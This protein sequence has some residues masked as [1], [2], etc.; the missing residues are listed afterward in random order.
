MFCILRFRKFPRKLASEFGPLPIDDFTDALFTWWRT[1]GKS[2]PAWALAA[3]VA[4]AIS[5]NSAACERVFALLKTMFGEQQTSALSDM[6]Q[7][8]LML[9]TNKRRLG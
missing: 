5:P 3:R 6:I 8:A 7:A 4:L 1:N 9:R 2:F